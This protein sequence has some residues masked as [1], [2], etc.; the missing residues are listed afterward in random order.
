MTAE[1]LDTII[2][3]Q[4]KGLRAAVK[5]IKLLSLKKPQLIKEEEKQVSDIYNGI[6]ESFNAGTKLRDGLREDQLGAFASTPRRENALRT[7]ANIFYEQG[8][9]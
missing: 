7:F 2:L 9:Y 1:R 5:A 3:S 8:C 4:A 6:K